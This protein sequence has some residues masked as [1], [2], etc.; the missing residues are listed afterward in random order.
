MAD[1][2]QPTR[3]ALKEE[4]AAL[5]EKRR[6]TEATVAE[7]LEYLRGT[8]VGM[9]E[10]L[11]DAE[12]F[13]RDDCD[14]YAV[15]QARQT[16]ICGRNDLR[17]IEE[18]LGEKLFTL[19]EG[20]R[21]EAAAQIARDDAAKAQQQQQQSAAAS[22]TAPAAD[23]AVMR[24]IEMLSALPPIL[25]VAAVE[26][27]SPAHDGGLR[28]GYR[29]YQYADLNAGNV[30]QIGLPAV[31][32]RTQEHEGRALSVWVRPAALVTENGLDE[33]E[34]REIIIVPQKWSGRGILG[35]ALDPV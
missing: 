21:E 35:C 24:M 4:I 5:A 29:V 15:R 11:V 13:P 14:L 31:A 32:A 12:G 9:T 33:G 7:A 17:D 6:A 26:P 2:E 1:L 8:P 19:M 10:P 28:A 18:E 20:G 3:D 25:T 30:R 22:G 27:G 34:L 23:P 16:V